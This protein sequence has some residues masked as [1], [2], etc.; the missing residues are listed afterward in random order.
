MM[1]E[2]YVKPGSGRNRICGYDEWRKCW[3]VEVKAPPTKGKANKELLSYLSEVF[4]AEVRIVKG[5]R[6]QRKIIQV[7]MDEKELLKKLEE[8]SCGSWS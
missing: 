3:V 1:L 6:G 4:G 8:L 5:E 2:I 7:N